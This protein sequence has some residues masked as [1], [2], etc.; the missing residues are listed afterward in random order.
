MAGYGGTRPLFIYNENMKQ[1]INYP[2]VYMENGYV[3]IPGFREFVEEHNIFITFIIGGRG[4]GKTYTSLK[5]IAVEHPAGQF[6]LVRRTQTQCDIL[7]NNDFSP[8][9][10]LN[11]DMG[12]FIGT[13]PIPA[14]A[15]VSRFT[16]DENTIG[17][18]AAL[19]TF[20]NARGFDGSEITDVVYDECIPE[21][22]ERLIKNE[23]EAFLNMLETIGRNRE[24]KGGKP[25]R[26]WC[27][28]NSNDLGN[29][30][31]M[32]LGLVATA[33]KMREKHREIYADF[34]R[35]YMIVL[36]DASPISDAKNQTALYRL[37]SG[38]DFQRMA[39]S[40]DFVQSEIMNIR[41]QQLKQY[42]PLVKVGEIVVYKHKASKTY[43]VTTHASGRYE[44]MGTGETSFKRFNMK[45]Y[46]L[47]DAYF[48]LR[49]I[50][51]NYYV[52][53]LFVKICKT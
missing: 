45:Y 2:A 52:E 27:L 20:K 48:D 24:I 35:G 28:A 10:S 5:D 46:Y 12:I 25:L 40:N 32:Y 47:W 9:K 49:V 39:I 6:M 7:S 19:S 23:A 50:F 31:F 42:K 15:N 18:L 44:D 41:P 16:R 43:Y 11:N 8:F 14:V 36:L 37:T 22:H 51:E 34:K 30:L 1:H 29:P 33:E 17:Y 26:V 21:K 38:S 3:N 4:T 13:E 53:R